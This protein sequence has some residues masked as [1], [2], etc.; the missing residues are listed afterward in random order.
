MKKKRFMTSAIACYLVLVGFFC[1]CSST[2]SKTDKTPMQEETTENAAWKAIRP[3]EVKNAVQLFDKD[4]MALAVGKEDDMNTMT[5]SWGG[6][7]ELWER[8]VV[9]VYVSTSRHTHSFME[10]NG[11][12][13]V[14]AFPEK[15]RSA[16]RYIGTHSGRDGDKLKAAGL[17][18]KYTEFGNP[19]FKEANLA[20]ECKIIYSVPFD[21]ERIDKEVGRIYD[22]GMSIHTMYIGEIVNVWKKSGV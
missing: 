12:F 18:P 14:T 7:G 15:H 9:T 5:I 19:I 22:N 8:P 17:T 1:S 21:P 3:E 4:W 11:Y 16:L 6:M 13:T 10:R 2:S 20:I